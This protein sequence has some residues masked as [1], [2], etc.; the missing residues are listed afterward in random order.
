L[1]LETVRH[2]LKRLVHRLR[3][4]FDAEE[5]LAGREVFYRHIHE[6]PFDF[7]P[8]AT[9]LGHGKGGGN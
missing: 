6:M 5:F 4:D 3:I 1:A 7:G 8:A 9:R 2:F